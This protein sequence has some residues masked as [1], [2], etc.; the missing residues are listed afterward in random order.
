[1]YFGSS[2][3]YSWQKRPSN[4]Q[5][6]VH[7]RMLSSIQPDHPSSRQSKKSFRE[8][9]TN[10]KQVESFDSFIRLRDYFEDNRTY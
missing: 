1:M 4:D 5:D 8:C 6:E 7:E 10:T 3:L 9:D 2:K